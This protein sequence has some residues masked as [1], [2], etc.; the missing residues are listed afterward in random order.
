[1]SHLVKDGANI[2]VQF[3]GD[4]E[5]VVIHG[6]SAGA[7]SVSLHLTVNQGKDEGLFVGAIAQ[8]VFVPSQPLASELEWQYERLVEQVGCSD[9]DDQMACVREQDAS[10]LQ[11]A[12]VAS[13]FP[14]KSS[15][16]LPLWYWTPCIDGEL[17]TE[18]TYA[19]FKHGKFIDVPAIFGN[20]NDGKWVWQIASRVIRAISD[21]NE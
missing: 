17:F 20:D 6:T 10:V 1:M 3:G 9:S 15:D 12:N 19:S 5:H 8:S 14:G 13:P 21:A 4:P 7:G 2:F 11:A 18:S 16:P